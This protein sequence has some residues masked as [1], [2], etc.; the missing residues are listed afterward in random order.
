VNKKLPAHVEKNA[1]RVY[2][3][4]H[5]S[6]SSW[7]IIK[8]FYKLRSIGDKVVVGDKIVLQSLIGV[9][10]LH[11]SESELLDHPGCKEINLLN[12]QTSWKVNLFMCHKEDKPNVLKSGDVIRLFHA[13]Q[14]KYLTCDE[15]ANK[16]HVFIRSTGRLSASSATSSKAL[17]EVELV[18]KDACRGGAS[19]WKNHFRF[20]HLASGNYLAAEVDNDLSSACFKDPFKKD[21]LQPVFS[22]VCTPNSTNNSTIFELDETTITFK[23]SYIPSNSYVRLRHNQTNSWIHSTSI[24]IDRDEEKPIMWKLCCSK[25]KEDK[26]A[27]QIITVP[28]TEVRDLDFANDAA[29]MLNVHAEKLFR[30]QLLTND[31]RS[32]SNLL[33]DLIYFVTE[34]ETD[35]NDPFQINTNKSNRERQKL[36][37]EQNVLQQIFRILKAPFQIY[38]NVNG[39]DLNDLKNN[40]KGFQQIF[41]LCYR[42]LKHSQESYRK[43]QVINLSN[44]FFFVALGCLN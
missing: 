35:N 16:Q 8:P 14:E 29:K 44:L 20:K 24:P 37:R 6:E 30:N 38:G 15:Y 34:S 22:L 41:R 13:E 4:Q 18:R 7:F 3:D 27:F 10:Q 21:E 36:I 5:G 28:K 23:E 25:V 43:N 42:V 11:V 32:L 39:I 31:K 1:M 40:R 17:W 12:S 33:A 9:Q 26:E 19:R 2:L